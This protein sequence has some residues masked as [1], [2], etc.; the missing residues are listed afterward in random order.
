MCGGLQK[1]RPGI[2]V[3]P[4]DMKSVLLLA[5]FHKVRYCK[6]RNAIRVFKNSGSGLKLKVGVGSLT[7]LQS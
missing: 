2:S 5:C 1:F 6:G 4:A 7:S 3:V